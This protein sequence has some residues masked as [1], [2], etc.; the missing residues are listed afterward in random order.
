MGLYDRWLNWF[1]RTQ[2]GVWVAMY[3]ANPIDKRLM[4]WTKG[5]LNFTS[6]SVFGGHSMLLRCTGAQSGK[7]RDVPVFAFD[8]DG[9]WVLIASAGGQER[10][11]AWYH[12][13]KAHPRCALLVPH[14]AEVACVAHE[15]DGDERERAWKAANAGYSGYTAYQQRTQRPIPVMV[16]RPEN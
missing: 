9:G 14:R 15:A 2:V 7:P 4:R 8:Y 13:L 5:S 16:L 3:V 6:G 10:N 12:N 1:M 11:P